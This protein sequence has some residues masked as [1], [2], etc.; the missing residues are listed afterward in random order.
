MHTVQEFKD[1]IQDLDV[2]VEF[3]EAVLEFLSAPEYGTHFVREIMD[4]AGVPAGD[5]TPMIEVLAGELLDKISVTIAD[6][7][8]GSD[9]LAECV[10]EAV[11]NF[12]AE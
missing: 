3:T 9:F 11:E 4:N 1:A 6:K 2:Q 12:L 8:R 7:L 5:D 10:K